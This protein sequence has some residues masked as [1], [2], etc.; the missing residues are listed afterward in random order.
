MKKI[1][2]ILSCIPERINELDIES[3]AKLNECSAIQLI[4]VLDLKSHVTPNPDFLSNLRVRGITCLSGYFGT[5]GLTR[6]H[7]LLNSDSEWVLFW[8]DDDIPDYDFAKELALGILLNPKH[9]LHVFEY[10]EFDKRSS[11]NIRHLKSDDFDSNCRNLTTRLGI[12]RCVLLRSRLG[13]SVFP[14][15]IMGED[16]CFIFSQDFLKEEIVFHNQKL[17]TYMK[18]SGDQ[19]TAQRVHRKE[20]LESWGFMAVKGTEAPL[21][22]LSQQLLCNIFITAL[23]LWGLA[24]VIRKVGLRNLVA[25]FKHENLS[26]RMIV[27]NVLNKLNRR[28]QIA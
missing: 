4:I 5:P 1:G 12:W 6:N 8:D 18:H 22:S 27:R 2:I 7:G 20:V 3:L 16:Q 26:L 10:L 11:R 23:R 28:I 24:P 13:E 9:P 25:N 15:L 21:N 17:Y 19:L 14:S